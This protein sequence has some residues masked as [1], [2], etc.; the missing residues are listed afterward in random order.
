MR[1]DFDRRKNKQQV[2]ARE[3]KQWGEK[4]RITVWLFVG[5]KKL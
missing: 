5:K 4:E 1:V 2:Y 3:K